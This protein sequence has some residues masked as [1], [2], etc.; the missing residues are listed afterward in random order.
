MA[1]ISCIPALAEWRALGPFGGPAALVRVD[2][3]EPGVV[4][5]A[6]SDGRLFRSRDGGDSWDD[7]HFAQHLRATIHD[8][9]IHPRVPGLYFAALSGELAGSSGL[10]VSSDS[11]ATWNAVKAFRDIPVRA[12]AVFRGDAKLL[13]AGTNTGVFRSDDAGHSWRPI[14]PANNRE[15]RPVVSVSFDPNDRLVIYAGTTHLPWKT[16]DGGK[17]WRSI[18]FGMSDDSDIFSVIVDR[19]RRTRVFAGACSG[20]YRSLDGGSAWKKSRDPILNSHRTY[21]VVQHPLY[22]NMI[23]TGM[24]GGLMRSQNGGDTWER[25]VPHT[26][27]SIAFDLRRLSRVY[28][29]TDEAGIIRSDDN[30]MTWQQVNRG[31]C[32][33]NLTPLTVGE[34]GAV[35]TSTVAGSAEAALFRLARGDDGWSRVST[36]PLRPDESL[37]A[38]AA[39]VSGGRIYAATARSLFVSSDGAATWT[40]LNTPST[41]PAL[42][43]LFSDP[44]APGRILAVAGSQ[45]FLSADFA[46]TWRKI[47][48]SGDKAVTSLIAIDLPWSMATSSDDILVSPDGENWSVGARLPGGAKIYGVIQA[49]ASELLAA[50]SAGLM[51]SADQGASWRPVGGSLEGNTV[52]AICRHPTQTS[53]LFAASHGSIH[54]SSD[55]GRTWSLL[56]RNGSAP[57]SVKQLA[58]VTGNPDRLLALT[59]HQ[60][61]F[62]LPLIP[63]PGRETAGRRDQSVLD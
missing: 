38:V 10:V 21:T 49:S 12:L 16:A 28:V 51:R 1:L 7:L 22:E 25:L 44:W 33:R 63:A 40:R 5:A 20:V 56:S 17:T 19:N 11:G 13:V 23:F 50:T 6:T 54:R 43:G 14:S 24:E 37:T 30:G 41:L 39:S 55:A 48:V 60:G 62:E 45:L 61:V 27:R 9:L 18:H 3:H 58:V 15:L 57:G 29:A 46:T 2:P 32:N 47:A 4:I 35:Y 52:Q 34:G 59:S 36:L 31:F 8:V 42:S 26:A 53:I